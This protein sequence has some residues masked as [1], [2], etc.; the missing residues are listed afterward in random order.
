M[1]LEFIQQTSMKIYLL[2]MKDFLKRLQ[3][4]YNTWWAKGRERPGGKKNF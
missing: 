1:D 3:P 4:F 2:W